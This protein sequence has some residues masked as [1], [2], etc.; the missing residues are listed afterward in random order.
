[1]KKSP[2]L[3]LS[4]PS[5]NISSSPS[6][7][8]FASAHVKSSSG[9][10]LTVDTSSNINSQNSSPMASTPT[11]LNPSTN[12]ERGV[13]SKEAIQHMKQFVD[14]EWTR[15]G[16]TAQTK[17]DAELWYQTLKHPGLESRGMMLRRL[18]CIMR[19]GG[20]FYRCNS[21]VK[22]KK[23]DKQQQFTEFD[24]ETGEPMTKD[25][26]YHWRP[27][28]KNDWPIAT[29][30]SHGGRLV[31]QLPK[32]KSELSKKVNNQSQFDYT[33]WTWLITGEVDGDLSQFISTAKSGD[34]CHMEGKILFKRLGATHGLSFVPQDG[35]PDFV[36][37][38]KEQLKLPFK[39]KKVLVEEKTSGFNLR[40]TK[41]LGTGEYVLRHHRHWGGNIPL[42]GDGL[43][44]GIT[45]QMVRANGSHGHLYMYIMTPKKDQYGGMMVGLEGSEWG[46]YSAVGDYHGVSAKSS[47]YS[48]SFGYKWHAKKHTDLTS[49]NGPGK[50]DCMY[51]D[52][53]D[54]WEFLIEKF[55]T[56]RDEWVKETS[57]PTLEDPKWKDL[58][59]N[60][61][62]TIKKSHL[63]ASRL[64]SWDKTLHFRQ[65][66]FLDVPNFRGHINLSTKAV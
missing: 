46:K 63:S 53:S 54:G 1:M 61:P 17:R 40:D 38:P 5:S 36:P 23:S 8:Q 30:L 44:R 50:Y 35:D 24:P 41:L 64:T 11:S 25:E 10:R 56:W 9:G 29:V 60:R 14:D 15:E 65:S 13:V 32:G 66:H 2:S 47:P 6:K 3:S 31:I 4:T 42:G 19:F 48:P 55:K 45:G 20:L 52:L 58:E 59:E 51:V 21:H 37:L 12:E 57:L 7:K 33:F 49:V 26:A 18:F 16:F 34:Q 27:W 39:K 28:Y 62:R 22:G 43:K